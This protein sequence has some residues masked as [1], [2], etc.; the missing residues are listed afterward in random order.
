MGCLQVTLPWNFCCLDYGSTIISR[1]NVGITSQ[2]FE[3]VKQTEPSTVTRGTQKGAL[4]RV[5][6]LTKWSKYEGMDFLFFNWYKLIDSMWL[7]SAQL[8]SFLVM[9]YARIALCG[10]F[11][12]IFSSPLFIII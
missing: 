8:K 6:V 5:L 12:E 9:N 1:I 2:L 3:V 4:Y 7:V 10:G 11:A